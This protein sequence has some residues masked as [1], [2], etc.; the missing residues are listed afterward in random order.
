MGNVPSNSWARVVAAY[1]I[2][3][4]SMRVVTMTSF[5][6]MTH[7]LVLFVSD[8]DSWGSCPTTGIRTAGA[9][10]CWRGAPPLCIDIPPPGSEESRPGRIL[11]ADG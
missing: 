11:E 10:A 4:P 8:S 9:M 5:I 7:F 6:F 1:T 2:N 3:S